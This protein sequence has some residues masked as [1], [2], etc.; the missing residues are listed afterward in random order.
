MKSSVHPKRLLRKVSVIVSDPDATDDD[1]SG[2]EWL[3]LPRPRK[4]KRIVHE[5][6]FL[7]E[8]SESSRD[9]CNGVK[10]SRKTS[11][12]Q[13]KYPVGV[14]QRPSGRFA[15]EIMNPI[16]RT[17]KWLGTYGTI[18][19]AEKAYVDKKVEYDTFATS[20][21]TVSSSV[22][23]VTS[24]CLRS[25]ASASVSCV[26]VDDLSKGKMSLN[27]DV[28][29]SGESTKEVFA[30]FDFSDLQIPDLSF[31]SAE[32]DSMVSGAND[33]ELDFDC[34]LTAESD[35]LLDDYSLLDDDINISGFENSIP[36]ELP[37]CDFT[38]MDLAL[39]DLKFAYADQL[40]PPPNIA[41]E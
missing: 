41:F 36:S 35:Y 1:S 7:S 26:S 30:S 39:G 20:C 23:S 3:S 10:T 24:Q 32:E 25:P 4:V 40:T 14:R 27:K 31:L 9:S 12:R 28:A 18:E 29:A 8:Y 34:F 5:I 15:A 6:T 16:T 13:A 33:A 22:I 21:S 19:E 17:K 2:D 37:E 11:T 38:D